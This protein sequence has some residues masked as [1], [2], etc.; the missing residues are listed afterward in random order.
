MLDGVVWLPT[1]SKGCSVHADL[2]TRAGAHV[3]VTKGGVA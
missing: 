1:N 2:G 3:T